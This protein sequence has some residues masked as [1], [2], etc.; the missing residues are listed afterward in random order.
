[1]P[2][3]V[4]Q[5]LKADQADDK[6]I[7]DGMNLHQVTLVG[8]VRS[9]KESSTNLSYEI[10]DMTGPFL[11][12]RQFVDNDENTPEA[13]KVA[14]VRE[15]IYVRVH[16]HVRAFAGKR[17]VAAFRV[18]PLT[19]MNELTSHLLEVIYAHAHWTK[20]QAMAT[21]GKGSTNIMG[22][23]MMNTTRSGFD[24]SSNFGGQ[25]DVGLTAQQ[26]QVLNVIRSCVDEQ[27]LAMGVVCDRLKGM[28]LKVVRDAVEFLSSEG[29]I[30]STIDDEHY[31]ATDSM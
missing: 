31:K 15:N 16:G 19:D 30:Y 6:F 24:T 23:S 1:M 2:C 25:V 20:G 27:G 21:P 4:A 14:L 17:N 28:P 13:E 7:I 5:I 3:T 11:E 18:V 29:H 26:Q 22:N 12:V 10:D 8:L 9:A